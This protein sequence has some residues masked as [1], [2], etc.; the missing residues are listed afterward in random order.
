MNDKDSPKRILILGASG[1]IGHKLF[2]TLS[3]GHDCFAVLH[4]TRHVFYECG[5]FE[6]ANTIERVD[7]KEI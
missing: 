6:N 5:L 7:V 2:E 4:Q 1:L 3:V